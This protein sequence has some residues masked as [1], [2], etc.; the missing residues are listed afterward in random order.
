VRL[1]AEGDM[2][3]NEWLGER[4][5]ALWEKNLLKMGILNWK[6]MQI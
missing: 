3:S 6:N 4:T 2:L 5:D 1:E